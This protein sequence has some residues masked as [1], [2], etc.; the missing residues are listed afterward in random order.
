MLKVMT[1]ST[2][3]KDVDVDDYG[4]SMASEDDGRLHVIVH[5]CV[6]RT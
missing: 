5:L 4:V 3:V 6:I 2:Y 1:W